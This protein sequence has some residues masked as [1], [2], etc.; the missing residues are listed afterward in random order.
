MSRWYKLALSGI[1]A[2]G[3]LGVSFASAQF[4]LGGYQQPQVGP[5]SFS[6]WLNMTRPG[7]GATNYYGMVQPQVQTRQQ[8]QSLQYQENLIKSGLGAPAAGVNQSAP[9]STTGHPVRFNDYSRY[10]PLQGMPGATGTIPGYGPNS[11]IGTGYG[12][13]VVGTTPSVTPGLPGG[14]PGMTGG[15]GPIIR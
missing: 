5:P 10:F 8:L 7:G 1:L 2:W 9:L 11:G 14:T 6:P 15:F 3:S 4:P 12:T 13:G